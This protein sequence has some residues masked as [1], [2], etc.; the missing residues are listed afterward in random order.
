MSSV[1]KDLVFDVFAIAAFGSSIFSG[2]AKRPF[3]SS[4]HSDFLFDMFKE[5]F[6]VRLF[7]EML[8]GEKG[9]FKLCTN[10]AFRVKKFTS[11]VSYQPNL[12][13]L[14]VE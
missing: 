14:L 5:P 11:L 7:G 10:F 9:F 3:S 4:S 8:A 1:S 2:S 12:F 13:L 6:V